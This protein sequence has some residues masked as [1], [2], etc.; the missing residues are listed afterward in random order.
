[1]RRANRRAIANATRIEKTIIRILS[2]VGR[3][4]DEDGVNVGNGRDDE[5]REATEVGE[6]VKVARSVEVEV[7]EVSKEVELTA[8]KPHV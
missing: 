8:S 5:A 4:C 3:A 7:A 1:M 6:D 2:C